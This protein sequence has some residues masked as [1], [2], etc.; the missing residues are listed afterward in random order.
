MS[1][2]ASRTFVVVAILSVIAIAVASVLM[3]RNYATDPDVQEQVEDVRDRMQARADSAAA[4]DSAS[5][6]TEVDSA[7]AQD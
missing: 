3:L 5:A 2:R 6:A 4:A 1:R 7:A